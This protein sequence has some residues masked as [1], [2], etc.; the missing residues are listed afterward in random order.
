MNRIVGALGVVCIAFSAQARADEYEIDPVHSRV[1]FA[2][3][4][5]VVSTVHGEFVKLKGTVSYDPKNPEATRLEVVIDAD[6]LS[7]RDAGRDGHLKGAD[8]FDVPKNPTIIFVSKKVEKAG[9]GDLKVLG[10]LTLRG[11]TK[12]VT[13]VVT[14]PSHEVKNVMGKTVRAASAVT[15]I[16]R[17]DFGMTWNKAMD[18][19]GVIIGDDVTIS[20]DAE[21]VKKEIAREAA[22]Q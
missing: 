18:G 2:V 11:V 22:A 8:F 12:P 19:G 13:L 1:G 9:K 3:K 5:L 16:R 21:L 6:S 20:I 10:D 14:G 17:K 7:T 15:T 4:H